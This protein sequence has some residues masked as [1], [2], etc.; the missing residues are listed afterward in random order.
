MIVNEMVE[1][2]RDAFMLYFTNSFYSDLRKKKHFYIFLFHNRLE[3]WSDQIFTFF[4]TCVTHSSKLKFRFQSETDKNIFCQ[5]EKVH[6]WLVY[7]TFARK[8]NGLMLEESE[9]HAV[10]KILKTI[11]LYRESAIGKLLVNRIVHV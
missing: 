7:L 9:I 5:I 3:I 4:S 10:F 11:K 2:L 6:L 1:K 8:E